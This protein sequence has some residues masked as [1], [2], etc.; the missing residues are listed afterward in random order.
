L[1]SGKVWHDLDGAAS[2]ALVLVPA[3]QALI[4]HLTANHDKARLAAARNVLESV[5]AFLEENDFSKRQMG[6]NR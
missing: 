2:D 1:R 5:T 6:N 4:N 3:E